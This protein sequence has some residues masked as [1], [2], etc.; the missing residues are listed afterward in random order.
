MNL[1]RNYATTLYDWL[2]TF[3]TTYREPVVFDSENPPPNEYIEYS[4]VTGN[5]AE[6]FI[7]PITI[8]SKSTSYKYVWEIA[9]AIEEAINESGIVLN[10]DL[11]YL[12]IMKGSPFYQDKT[13]EDTS[14][15]AG[16]INLLVKIYQRGL[17]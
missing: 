3:A 9:D 17:K 5:F 16:Y 8:Y 6:E 13:D 15:R 12:R 14:V 1:T 7:Q 10:S 2:S 4:A 11:G